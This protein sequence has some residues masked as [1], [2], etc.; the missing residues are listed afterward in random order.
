METNQCLDNMARKENEKVGIFNC[1]GMG[2]NQVSEEE[3]NNIKKQKLS[4]DATVRKFSYRLI[5]LWF[6][7]HCK[8]P[9]AVSGLSRSLVKLFLRGPFWQPPG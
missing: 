3:K 4:R 8:L 6:Q 2:G 5:N 9:T 7:L 1:H